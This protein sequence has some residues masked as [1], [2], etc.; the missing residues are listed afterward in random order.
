MI[1]Y[2]G[3]WHSHPQGVPTIPSDDDIK[4]FAWIT[5]L[6]DRDGLPALMM[7]VGDEDEISCFVTKIEQ[8]ENLFPTKGAQ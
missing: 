5:E 7:I 4:V 1:E 8:V 2:I 6:M 3:E